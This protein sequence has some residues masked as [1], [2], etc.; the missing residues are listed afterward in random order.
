MVPARLI[1]GRDL[2]RQK[3]DLHMYPG[4]FYWRK[5]AARS[6][7]CGGHIPAML[8]GGYCSPAETAGSY[9]AEF[10][11]GASFGVRR[12]LR[13]LA[14]KLD[15]DE[16]QTAELAKILADLKT[17]RAQADVETR[18]AASALAD[19]ASAA[20]FDV[21]KA[22]E[23]ADLKVKS[24]ERVGS[25]LVAALSR[26]HALLDQDQRERLAYLVRTG[27]VQL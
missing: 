19:L 2:P 15:L 3:E 6:P 14:W 9:R 20:E 18:R 25:A 5:R 1:A 13:F 26:L 4:F 11:P 10:S 17:E 27:V 24:A 21:A 23:A 22:K 8:A 7:Y 16:K 12:P